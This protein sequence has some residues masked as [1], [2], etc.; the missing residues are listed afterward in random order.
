MGKLR[1]GWLTISAL[2][3][4]LIDRTL[5]EDGPMILPGLSCPLSDTKHETTVPGGHTVVYFSICA[6]GLI[7]SHPAPPTR[8]RM[9]IFAL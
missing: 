7:R 6:R 4:G 2:G 1:Y 8:P 5:L 3:G 9:D